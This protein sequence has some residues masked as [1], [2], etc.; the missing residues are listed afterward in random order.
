MTTP[1]HADRRE[2][3]QPDGALDLAATVD[4]LLAQARTLDAG[5][6]A[7][8]LTPGAGARLK[9]TVLVLV[10]GAHLQDHRAPGPATIQV[11]RGSVVLGT[12]D[13]S[14]ELSAG[15]WAVIRDETHDVQ[16]TSDAGLLL[17]VTPR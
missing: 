11:L 9:Q 2:P 17:T 5:R 14:L 4:D 8:T 15:D 3:G 7:R 13:S 1:V 16:A 6:S 10:Q 12:A